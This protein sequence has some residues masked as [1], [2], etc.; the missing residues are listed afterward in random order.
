[1][2]PPPTLLVF[3]PPNMVCANT[4]QRALSPAVESGVVSVHT[5]LGG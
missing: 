1:M 2:F 3:G 5:G 4:S